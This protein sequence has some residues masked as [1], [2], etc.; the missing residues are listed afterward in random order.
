MCLITRHSTWHRVGKFGGFE[1]DVGT[2]WSFDKFLSVAVIV[3]FNFGQ[4]DRR[5][6]VPP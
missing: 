4:I 2:F 3:Q 5:K 1:M 6:A